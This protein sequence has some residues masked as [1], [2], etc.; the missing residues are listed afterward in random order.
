MAGLAAGWLDCRSLAARWLV[1][2]C[3]LL[4]LAVRLAGCCAGWLL[5]GCLFFDE[6]VCSGFCEK[7]FVFDPL[8]ASGLCEQICFRPF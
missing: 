3:L 1:D 4:V 7:R 2:D 8:F 6:F 5:R